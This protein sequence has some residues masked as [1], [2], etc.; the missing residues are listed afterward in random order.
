MCCVGVDGEQ[1]NCE[2]PSC[3]VGELD[4][5]TDSKCNE[6]P[7]GD[8]LTIRIPANSTS[9]EI[10]THDGQTAGDGDNVFEVCGGNGNQGGACSDPTA[11]CNLIFELSGTG[12]FGCGYAPSTPAPGPAPAASPTEQPTI[13][14]T[15]DPLAGC[16]ED[17]VLV[18]CNY[19]ATLEGIVF[20]FEPDPGDFQSICLYTYSVD[21]LLAE[22]LGECGK[23]MFVV[24][25]SFFRLFSNTYLC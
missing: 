22:G 9:F 19:T 11:H 2:V 1:G 23:S 16:G 3:P 17:A 20:C 14:P 12:D 18:A 24:Y 5:P 13:A 8:G 15:G 25:Q 6:I 7:E 10:N 21:K 4:G